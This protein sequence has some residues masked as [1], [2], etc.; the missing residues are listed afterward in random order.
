LTI[1]SFLQ[2]KASALTHIP[3]LPYIHLFR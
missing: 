1:L 3:T 2:M